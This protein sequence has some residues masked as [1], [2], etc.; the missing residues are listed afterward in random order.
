MKHWTAFFLIAA[1]TLLVIVNACNR[2]PSLD[3][4]AMSVIQSPQNL[5]QSNFGLDFWSDQQKRNTPLWQRAMAYCNQPEH[6]T[7]QNC[8]ALLS[9]PGAAA[10]KNW[11][12]APIAP[13]PSESPPSAGLVPPAKN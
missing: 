2:S 3:D 6:K 13:L 4:Q 12:K 1:C 11:F 7:L 5:A 9:V 10:L 8:E